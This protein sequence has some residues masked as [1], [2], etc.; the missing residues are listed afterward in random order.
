[1]RRESPKK[2]LDKIYKRCI[3]IPMRPKLNVKRTNIYLGENQ[4][5]QLRKLSDKKGI[6]VSELIRR[7]LDQWLEK[8]SQKERR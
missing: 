8:Q 5:E 3:L 1:M 2:E 4:A 6:T 7:V